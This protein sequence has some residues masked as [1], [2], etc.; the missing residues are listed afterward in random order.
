M[1]KNES[2]QHND[3]TFF[4]LASDLPPSFKKQNKPS[5]GLFSFTRPT[6]RPEDEFRARM[7]LLHLQNVIHPGSRE[8]LKVSPSSTTPPGRHHSRPLQD[9]YASTSEISDTSSPQHQSFSNKKLNNRQ[10]IKR[11]SSPSIF[12]S[13][14]TH[15]NIPRYSKPQP[16]TPRRSIGDI[17]VVKRRRI[18]PHNLL[19]SARN[20]KDAS[21]GRNR[22]LA[23]AELP[24]LEP[25]RSVLNR[26]ADQSL[27]ALPISPT[28]YRNKDVDNFSSDVEQDNLTKDVDNDIDSDDRAIEIGS[29]SDSLF[30]DH[31]L[32]ENDNNNDSDNLFGD[33][34]LQEMSV[35]EEDGMVRERS[36]YMSGIS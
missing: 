24:S 9:P 33:H 21:T 22:I 18:T 20:D 6:L 15:I 32:Q 34:E 1:S 11:R 19:K 13:T 29:D 17:V 30:G 3:A 36:C 26:P 14:S 2:S 27:Y 31:E 4:P 28:S 16:R 5:S 25:V 10:R 8:F 7:N 23:N 12:G 35:D